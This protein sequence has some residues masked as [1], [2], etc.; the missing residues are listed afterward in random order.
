MSKELKLLEKIMLVIP[1]FR[2]YKKR[3]L[4]REDDKLVREK[5]AS[6]L[7]DARR[8]L[9]RIMPLALPLMGADVEQM[10]RLR[11][12]LMMV[13]S[14]IRH[15]EH[16]Y[17]GY[18]DRIKVEERELMKLYEYDYKL[19]KQAKQILRGVKELRKCLGDKGRMLSE[20]LSL[21]LMIGELDD[22]I[23]RRDRMFKVEG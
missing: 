4:I 2:G 20:V 21:T 10:D 5:V 16:G 19:I 23:I 17:A 1:G 18:F 12:K 7:D 13:S 11:K 6:M 9:E 14:K 22:L 15:A 8:E 3:E